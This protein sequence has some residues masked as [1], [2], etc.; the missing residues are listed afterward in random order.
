MEKDSLYRSIKNKVAGGKKSV[1]KPLQ[2]GII[3]IMRAVVD[4]TKLYLIPLTLSV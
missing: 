3:S 1:E 4:R 2:S